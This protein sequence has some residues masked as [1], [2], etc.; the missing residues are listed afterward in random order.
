MAEGGEGFEE[1]DKSGGFGLPPPPRLAAARCCCPNY[2]LN[3]LKSFKFDFEI[4]LAWYSHS[5]RTMSKARPI[6]PGTT[7]LITR[8][9]ERR[10]CLLRPDLVL[11]AFVLYSF[12]VSARRHGI[13][14]HA[15][16]VMSTHMHYVI[17]DPTGRLPRFLELFHR[18]AAIGVK[19]I[20]FWDGAVWDRSQTSVVELGS[21]QAI[22]EKI[23]YTLANPVEAGLVATAQEWP[24]IK[25]SVDDIGQTTLE[26]KRPNQYFR[27]KNPLWTLDAFL[28]VTLP[29]SI[30]PSEAQAFRAE[31]Q[32]ELSDRE[33]A[34]GAKFPPHTVLGAENVIKVDPESRTTSHEPKFQRQPTFALGRGATKAMREAMIAKRRAFQTAYAK[35]FEEWRAGNRTITFPAGTYAMHV[36]HKVNVASCE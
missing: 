2:A 35:A 11:N 22:V 8:R 5:F 12:I 18:L 16:C 20:R 26:A 36:I 32:K 9:T 27:A 25:T 31:I 21:R 33:E 13:L 6:H 34:A 10:H 23:A 24:G 28:E 15:F 1:M 30:D 3:L 19:I 29:P 14:L 7:Y 4:S 17:T